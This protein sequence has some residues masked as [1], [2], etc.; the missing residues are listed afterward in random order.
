M[1]EEITEEV[2]D[3]LDNTEV[4]GEASWYWQNGVPGE[5][6]APE[7]LKPK[8]QSVA[9]QAKAY[10]ALESRFG[11]FTGAPEAYEVPGAEYF[12]K[13]IDLPEGVDFNLD[14]SDPLLASFSELAKEM[15]L[16]QDG[17]NKMVGLYIKQQVN[18]YGAQMEEKANQK[19]LLGEN[20][21]QRLTA[22]AQWGRNN[23]D[24]DGYAKLEE[25]LQTA[26]AVEV[27]EALIA[28]TR[29]AKVPTSSQVQG[30]PGI[31][32]EDYDAEFAKKGPN[33]EWLYQT[34]PAHRSKVRKMA[35]R[36]F[37]TEPNKQIMG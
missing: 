3:G 28:K 17:Y 27:V 32:K 14:E 20:A 13:D 31:T 22:I 5:G 6:E 30:A 10:T 1:S 12:M 8:Y 23:L 16:S 19:K 26:A 15:N 4:D 11:S 35:D 9:D 25:S 18:D 29:N 2:N 33:G 7:W 21:D 24:E 34:D 36:L 37:G